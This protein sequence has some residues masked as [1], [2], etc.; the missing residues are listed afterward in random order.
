MLLSF[1]GM[2]EVL[3]WPARLPLVAPCD[4]ARVLQL[5]AQSCK[6]RWGAQLLWFVYTGIVQA[7]AGVAGAVRQLLHPAEVWDKGACVESF[8]DD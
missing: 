6:G 8:L 2:A 3:K 7:E 5:W 4:R 1:S